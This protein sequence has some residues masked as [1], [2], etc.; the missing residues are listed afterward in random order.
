MCADDNGLKPQEEENDDDDDEEKKKKKDAA[1]LS[2]MLKL[3]C[4]KCWDDGGVGIYSQSSAI[5]IAVI[6][7]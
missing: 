7:C 4:G 6:S 3:T 1:A 2:W 5:P